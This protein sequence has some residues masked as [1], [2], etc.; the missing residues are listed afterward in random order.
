M[1]LSDKEIISRIEQLR[2]K[3]AGAKTQAEFADKAGVALST[4]TGF[5]RGDTSVFNKTFLKLLGA[6]DMSIEE[7][8][9][10]LIADGQVP[11][12][13]SEAFSVRTRLDEQR[14]YYEDKISELQREIALLRENN[15]HLKEIADL[16][17]SLRKMD[18]R[19]NAGK[20]TPQ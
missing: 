18:A 20:D 14:Q 11:G 6:L 19:L 12:I 7:F 4:Y 3:D 8:F 5:L 13:L 16:Q 15:A 2:K 10:P 1:P 17:A 9:A